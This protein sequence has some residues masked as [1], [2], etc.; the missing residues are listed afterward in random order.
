[1][2]K[3]WWSTA[4]RIPVVIFWT[5]FLIPAALILGVARIVSGGGLL[6]TCAFVLLI[7]PFTVGAVKRLHDLN[8]PGW[9]GFILWTIGPSLQVLWALF[10]S[11]SEPTVVFRGWSEVPIYSEDLAFGVGAVWFF[12]FVF[13]TVFI[14]LS[15]GRKGSN[16]YG[17][18]PLG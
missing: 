1:M 10:A 17:P 2:S 5:R 14:S 3:L 6:F 18:N 13:T 15:P 16:K 4:G 7:W 8:L 9:I 11:T 12:L